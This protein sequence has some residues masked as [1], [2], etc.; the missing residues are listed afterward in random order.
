MHQNSFHTKGTRNK[1]SW[2]K[3]SIWTW[4]M[5]NQ[6]SGLIWATSALFFS[7]T[8]D[9]VN[10]VFSINNRLPTHSLSEYA[11]CFF[12]VISVQQFHK[13]I[14]GIPCFHILNSY[15]VSVGSYPVSWWIYHP[16]ANSSQI[17]GF[18][19]VFSPKFQACS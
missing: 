19:L 2:R 6:I 9:I 1:T 5:V 17:Y 4:P 13:S 3:W 14:F 8:N 18:F 15:F 10:T 12:I 11:P 16:Q 7:F